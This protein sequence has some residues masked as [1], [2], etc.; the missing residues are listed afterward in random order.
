[1]PLSTL[2]EVHDPLRARRIPARTGD[3]PPTPTDVGRLDAELARL[4]RGA[5]ALRLLAGE[6]LESMGTRGLFRALGFPSLG[7]YAVERASRSVRWVEDSRALARRLAKLPSTRAAMFRGELGWRMAEVLSRRVT[8][9]S[10]TEWLVFARSSTVRQVK[11][12]L[13]E[14]AQ[15]GDTSSACEAREPTTTLTM[16]V[17]A[18]E[19]W[20]MVSARMLIDAIGS[21]TTDDEF[22]DGLLAEAWSSMIDRMEA[23]EIEEALAEV[24]TREQSDAAQKWREQLALWRREAEKRCEARLALGVEAEPPAEEADLGAMTARQLDERIRRLC[25]ELG[26]RDLRIGEL[27]DQFR[28][29]DGWRQLGFGSEQQYVRERVGVSMASLKSRRALARRAGAL[30]EVREALMRGTIGY[31]AARVV[32]RISTSGHAAAWLD[33]ARHRT[34]KH[35]RQEADI[36]ELVATFSKGATAEPPSAE[37]VELV[38]RA[39]AWVK[40]GGTYKEGEPVGQMSEGQTN[41][42]TDGDPARS[43]M[44]EGHAS[45]REDSSAAASGDP[46]IMRLPELSRPAARVVLRFRVSRSIRDFF[47][48]FKQVY[49]R[50]RSDGTPFVSFLVRCLWNTWRASFEPKGAYADVYA[51][52]R[53]QCVSPVCFRHDAQPHHIIKRSEGGGDERSNV[54]T[55]CTECHLNGVH[56]GTIRFEGT[57]SKPRFDLG[58]GFLVVEGRKKTAA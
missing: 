54:V 17:E 36:A 49:T 16:R 33:R 30:P 10:E 39:E 38:Q 12:R 28:R 29:A 35:L 2:N 44:G 19:G 14:E 31:E 23:S 42:R 26:T 9:E 34:V 56:G 27:W 46:P 7:A 58:N 15:R 45:G 18:T 50:W 20:E 57:A 43:Q 51:R 3:A 11:E 13:E 1:M 8:V 5:A 52:D 47:Y 37:M 4:G 53:H 25:E 22:L 32:A 48:E 40:S 55:L 21:G 6:A 41:G 24:G